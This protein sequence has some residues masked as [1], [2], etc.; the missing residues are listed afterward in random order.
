MA[1]RS[2]ELDAEV[3]ASRAF[4]DVFH[5]YL[6]SGVTVQNVVIDMVKI[7]TDSESTAEES[8]A[9]L[10]TIAD[11]LFPPTRYREG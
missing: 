7:I 5:L 3:I 2:K 11:A 4:V 1:P 9:A 10:V 6:K 8:D